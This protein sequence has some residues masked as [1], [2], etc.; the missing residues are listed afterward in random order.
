MFSRRTVCFRGVP[1]TQTASFANLI[2]A[3]TAECG[4]P[5]NAANAAAGARFVQSV[6]K[7]DELPRRYE[8]T[9]LDLYHTLGVV[10]VR[11]DVGFTFGEGDVELR[12]DPVLDA[13]NF[14][15]W[16]P[17]TVLGET[18]HRMPLQMINEEG[19]DVADDF[20]ENKGGKLKVRRR[21]V[22]AMLTRDPDIVRQD[23]LCYLMKRI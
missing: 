12:F 15:E 18:S 22:P 16:G 10:R 2:P 1:G 11:K 5:Q 19:R 8:G 20:F 17:G 9:E 7:L 13:H 21:V 14:R 23:C 6:L 3:V 4:Q